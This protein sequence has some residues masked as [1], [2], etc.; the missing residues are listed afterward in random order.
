[1]RDFYQG[2]KVLI[3][4]HTGFQGAWLSQILLDW[5][6]D[7]VGVSLPPH[8]DPNLFTIFGLEKRIKNYLLDIREFDKLKEVFKKEQPEIV[9]HLAA[10]AIVLEGYDDPIGTYTTNVIGTAN[11]LET[12]RFTPSVKSLVVVTTDKVYENKEI[13]RPYVEDDKLGGYDPYSASKAATDIMTQSYINSFFNPKNYKNTQ[14]SLIG[15]ARSGNV[16]GGGDWGNYRLI[17]DMIRAVYQEQTEMVIRHPQSVRPWQHVFEPLLGYVVLAKGLYEGKTNLVGAWNFG[18]AEDGCLPVEEVIKSF[19]VS[20][21]QGSYRVEV[22][23]E[24]HEAGLLKLDNNKAKIQLGW[25]PKLSL[26]DC[27]KWTAEWYRMYYMEND[28]IL[29]FSKKHIDLFFN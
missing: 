25:E 23:N 6:A 15:I 9:F 4:G 14:S 1:M 13:D 7:V 18:P 2:K 16:I 11:I 12:I 28:N 26:E 19:V 27:L 8:T 29:D 21:G 17:P 20:L 3:T 22:N 5:G 24:K 10:Q